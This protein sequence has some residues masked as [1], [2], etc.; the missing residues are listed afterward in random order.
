M[1]RR[2]IVLFVTWAISVFVLTGVYLA[3]MMNIHNPLPPVIVWILFLFTGVF[4]LGMMF[5]IRI[6]A[7]AEKVTWL[8]VVSKVL[9]ISYS[10]WSTLGLLIFFLSRLLI[11]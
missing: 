4:T 5:A 8:A 3:L 1:K 2:S 7:T 9:L 10:A 11:R 6:K